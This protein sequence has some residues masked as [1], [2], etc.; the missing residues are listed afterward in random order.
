MVLVEK[1]VM[2]VQRILFQQK[3]ILCYQIPL[4]FGFS[5]RSYCHGISIYYWTNFSLTFPPSG[6]SDS[7]IRSFGTFIFNILKLFRKCSTHFSSHFIKFSKHVKVPT[8]KTS[9]LTSFT[10]STTTTAKQLAKE[11]I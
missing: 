5:I 8:T 3:E 6:V 7:L 2:V 4:I 9:A 10:F 11:I 1:E